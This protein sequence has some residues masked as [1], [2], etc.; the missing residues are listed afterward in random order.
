MIDLHLH[1][2]ASDGQLTPVAL[3]AA[4]RA[5]GLTTVAVTDHDTVA[6]WPDLQAPADAEGLTLVA[7]IEITAVEAGRDVHVLG[8]F[9]DPADP[10]LAAFLT[11]QRFDRRRRLEAMLERLAAVGVRLDLALPDGPVVSGRALGRPMVAAALVEAGHVTSVAEAFDLYLSHGR[12]AYVPRSGAPVRE[13]TRL[14]G[15]AG[16]VG[17]LAHPGKLEDDRLVHRLLREGCDGVEVF[18]PDHS[19]SDR[20]RYLALARQW[21]LMVTGGSDFHGPGSGRPSAL[22]RVTLPEKYFGRLTAYAGRAEPAS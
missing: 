19:P 13:V 14:L 15:R 8:Y 11:A 1:T 16:G 2:T 20:G 3:V 10:E 4:A 17:V 7:G 22:G 5:A 21:R 9:F 12:P 18:H 6:A